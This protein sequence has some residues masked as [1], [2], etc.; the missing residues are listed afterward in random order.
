MS[1]AIRLKRTGLTKGIPDLMLAVRRGG[2]GGL[3]IEMKSATGY[4]EKHQKEKIEE[5]RAQGYMV[6]IC[7]SFEAFKIVIDFY[8]SLDAS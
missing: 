5:L 3:F 6:E 2:Y 1:V 7:K 4:P 8:L